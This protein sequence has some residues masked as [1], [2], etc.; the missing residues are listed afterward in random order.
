MGVAWTSFCLRLCFLCCLVFLVARGLQ[1]FPWG[2][3]KIRGLAER[4]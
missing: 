4:C 3:L 2:S 1:E